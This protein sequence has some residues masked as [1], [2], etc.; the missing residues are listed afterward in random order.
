MLNYELFTKIC[1]YV[2][3]N[4][5]MC[6][7]MHM[8]SLKYWII[9]IQ[10]FLSYIEIMWMLKINFNELKNAINFWNFYNFI[11][12][13][14]ILC[15]FIQFY[16]ICVIFDKF[17]SKIFKKEMNKFLTSKAK[18]ILKIA[19]NEILASKC[20]KVLLILGA[21]GMGKSTFIRHLTLRLWD[22]YD[23][24]KMKKRPLLYL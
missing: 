12:F 19:V 10:K 18:K 20:K 1:N 3:K 16:A 15:K 14:T 7:K 13:N 9:E 5:I 21:G 6:K 11:Q 23:Q 8:K 22:E 17:F 24:Q 4:A 2:R